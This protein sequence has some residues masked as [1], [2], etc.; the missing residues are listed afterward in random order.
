MNSVPKHNTKRPQ[1]ISAMSLKMIYY[2]TLPR[3]IASSCPN[4][5]SGGPV[6]RALCVSNF[7][8]LPFVIKNDHPA[9]IQIRLIEKYY[10]GEKI[11]QNLHDL[12]YVS[13][14]KYICF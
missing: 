1:I 4:D 10:S 7:R 6:G 12:N 5:H 11:A 8:K 13:H 14:Q 3:S 9:R 2:T